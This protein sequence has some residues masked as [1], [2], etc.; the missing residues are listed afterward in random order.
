MSQPQD[1]S[2]ASKPVVV[3]TGGSGLIGTHVL[4]ELGQQ[5]EL[6]VLD[7]N[8]PQT[9]RDQVDF[10]ETDFTDE[11]SVKAAC[12][13][14]R[15]QH[16]PRIASVIHLVAYYNF[17]G[18]PSP[19]YDQLTVEGTRKFLRQL[20]QASLT[21]D[22]FVFSS[23]LLVMKPQEGEIDETSETCAEWAYPQ[24][25]LDAEDVI[26]EERGETPVVFLRIAGV[27]DE[28]CHSLPLSQQITRIYEKQLESW[29]FPGDTSH[30]QTLVHLED[31]ARCIHRVIEKRNELGREE[32]FLVGEPEVL[33]YGELQDRIGELIHGKEWTTIRIPKVVAKAGAWVQGHLA[34]DDDSPFIKPWMVDLADAN[35]NVN[36][37]AARTKL[38]WEPRHELAETL[39]SMIEFLKRDPDSFYEKNNLGAS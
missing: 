27:Y 22:Q 23:S 10:I 35:Y 20:K 1:H 16:G 29:V 34:S 30:G 8:P 2:N 19:L 18:E 28:E 21:V 14:V 6:V 33:S 32:I 12:E 13:S 26:R 11:S 31:L 24:S 15:E 37:D 17:S 4:D 3:V 7:Q 36:V 25:K 9:M 5:Y 39:P 38:D